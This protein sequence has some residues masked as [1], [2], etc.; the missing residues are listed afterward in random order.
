MISVRA[1]AG[2][3]LAVVLTS[4]GHL[5]E[6]KTAAER[7]A[8]PSVIVF[9]G[10]PLKHRVAIRGG[11]ETSRL[12]SLLIPSAV[13]SDTSGRIPLHV[14][15]FYESSAVWANRALDS[16]PFVTADIRALYYPA[17]GRLPAL[18]I[19]ELGN[20]SRSLP[21][22]SVP[23]PGL[24]FLAQFGVPTRSGDSR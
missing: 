7:Y 17:Q 24:R 18:L 4:S 20:W 9:S 1:V 13:G 10:A 11:K 5:F 22:Q 6:R 14:A 2:W 3:G 12:L 23:E 8:T 21:A 16:I 15:M 19:P